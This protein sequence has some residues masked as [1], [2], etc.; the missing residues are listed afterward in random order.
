M[1]D[2]N[3]KKQY[4]EKSNDQIKSNFYGETSSRPNTY[5]ICTI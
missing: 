1:T 5:N 2:V 4:R 3:T